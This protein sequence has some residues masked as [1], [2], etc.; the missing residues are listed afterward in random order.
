M[1]GRAALIG[2]L[3][4]VITGCGT[5]IAGQPAGTTGTSST[6]TTVDTTTVT[7]SDFHPRR[8]ELP[9]GATFR[10]PTD[11]QAGPHRTLHMKVGDVLEIA[12]ATWLPDN[13]PAREDVIGDVMILVRADHDLLT[14]EM[15]SPGSVDVVVGPIGHPGGCDRPGRN[16]ADATPPPV[17]TIVVS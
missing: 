15:L 1:I 8:W 3:L 4:P 10:A 17:L 12:P 13:P 7:G 5:V 14:Y 2:L 9:R 11:A 6:V 16:C